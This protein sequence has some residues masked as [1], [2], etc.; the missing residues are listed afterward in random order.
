MKLDLSDHLVILLLYLKYFLH[1]SL[2]TNAPCKAHIFFLQKPGQGLDLLPQ[3][4]FY[5]RQLRSF[6]FT[7]LYAVIAKHVQEC[8]GSGTF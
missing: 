7:Y 3:V 5:Y 1:Q 6:P 8:P 2:S 4:L